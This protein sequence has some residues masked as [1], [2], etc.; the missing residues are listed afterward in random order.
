MEFNRLV[1]D[2]MKSKGFQPS[3]LDPC[4]YI[5]K[6]DEGPI[7]VLVYVDDLIMIGKG[8]QYEEFV[9]DTEK[10]FTMPKSEDLHWYLGLKFDR[11]TINSMTIDQELFIKKKLDLFE[12]IIGQVKRSTALP[13][14]Y[15]DAHQTDLEPADP[16]FPYRS[17]VGGLMYAM[18]GSR[19]DI[20]QAVSTVSKYLDK[21]SKTHC[22]LVIHIYQYLRGNS[23]KIE[24][25]PTDG[26]VHIIAY[27]DAS[28]SNM[29]ERKSL[30]GYAILLNGCLISW[31]AQRQPV[32][33][34][35]TAE[36]ELIAATSA[37]QE[38]LWFREILE[39]LGYP[40]ETVILREDNQACIE[41][42]KFPAYDH[43]RTKHIDVRY[44]WI[45]D[46]IKN[47]N[48]KFEYCP[49]KSQWADIFTKQLAGPQLR[50]TISNFMKSSSQGE[51]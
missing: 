51:N 35:S 9:E 11:S 29:E 14:T 22:E 15:D 42:G 16:E 19:P 12:P 27:C 30:S 33:A 18:V 46:H 31:N 20:A 41:L 21:P 23:W 45:R 48:M 40:Q 10:E 38:I 7:Y 34:L 13:L 50:S 44:F 5:K 17:M 28:Y 36:A 26:K 8:K 24:F 47:G 3:K 2:Y 49:T 1:D 39:E 4:I 43:K 37:G 25:N 6:T 32:V